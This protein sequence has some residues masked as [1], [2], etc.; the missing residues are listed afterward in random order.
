MVSER[1][2]LRTTPESGM[3]SAFDVSSDEEDEDDD[4]DPDETTA[5]TAPETRARP[6]SIVVVVV[7]ASRGAAVL[8]HC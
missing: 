8:G 4:E 7:G 3:A 1:S 2:G 5:G 6:R